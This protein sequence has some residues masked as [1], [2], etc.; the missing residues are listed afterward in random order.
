MSKTVNT[1]KINTRTTTIAAAFTDH[2][3]VK[4][5]LTGQQITPYWGKSSWKLNTK[6]LHT[7]EIYERFKQ[8]E[9]WRK[10]KKWYRDIGHWWGAC[11]KP[12]IQR[13]FKA[14]GREKA[15]E[16]KQEVIFY[17]SCI[18]EL[19]KKP[20]DYPEL[21]TKFKYYNAKIIQLYGY[22]LQHILAELRE[23]MVIP[24]QLTLYHI[25][26]RNKRRQKW[27]ITGIIDEEGVK[28]TTS[29][30]IRTTIYLKLKARFASIA[31]TEDS[32]K[33]ICSTITHTINDEEKEHMEKTI[34]YQELTVAKTQAPKR[35]SPGEDGIA[36]ELYGWGKDMMSED[37][38]QLYNN[39]LQS[40]TIP[41]LQTRG[42]IVCLPKNKEPE[43]A[44]DYRPLTL[45]NADHKIYARILANRLKPKM[46][47]VIQDTQYSAV[48]GQNII[49][50]TSTIRDIIAAGNETRRG[51]CL[52]VLDF[53]RAFDISHTYLHRLLGNTTTGTE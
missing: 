10:K 6:L 50:T 32:M 36:A 33:K 51:I 39:F 49:D 16:Y 42:I 37:M 17:Y 25:I 48:P 13:F 30:S 21:H 31:V 45:L 3:A 1:R 12:G 27:L 52:I 22:Q 23:N 7:E 46:N 24:E 11:V 41:S 40:G 44:K 2:N 9:G 5:Q 35:K 29:K 4:L 43:R 38:L 18:Y 19:L 20:I 26:S 8:W 34:T 53:T 47:D 15:S 28:Q 14:A